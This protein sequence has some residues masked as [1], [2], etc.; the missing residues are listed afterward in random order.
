MTLYSYGSGHV[1]SDFL[2]FGRLCACVH[3]LVGRTGSG[4]LKVT[5]V[6]LCSI[7]VA[8]PSV[9]LSVRLSITCRC[10]D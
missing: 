10:Y 7:D 1:G 4:H 6:Q 2:I 5:H 3:E 9:R 8:F